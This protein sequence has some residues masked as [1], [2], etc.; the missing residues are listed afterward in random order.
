MIVLHCSDRFSKMSQPN[1]AISSHISPWLTRIAY[2]LGTHIVLPFYFGRIE[3]TGQENIPRQGPL[4]LAPTHRSRWD[5]LVMPLATGKWAS[6]RDLHYMISSNE[7]KGVQ[8]WF[9]KR[10]G[11][12]PVDPTRPGIG[13]FRHSVKLLRQGEA[14]VIFPEGDIYREPKVQPLKSGVARIALEAQ[15]HLPEETVKILP[16]SLSYSD[17]YPTWGCDVKVEIGEPLEVSDYSSSSIRKSAAR[18]TADL[19][20]ALRDLHEVKHVSSDRVLLP[21]AS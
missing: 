3:V 14:L 4:I 1:E 20:S 18:L 9:M 7:Y 5:A 13:S 17:P 12:F 15:S 11:G 19:E 21:T 6:G 16:I 2:P 8:G 10:L